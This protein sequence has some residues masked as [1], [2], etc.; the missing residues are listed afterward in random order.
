MLLEQER[1]VEPRMRHARFPTDPDTQP[2]LLNRHTMISPAWQQTVSCWFVSLQCPRGSQGLASQPLAP[3]VVG[4]RSPPAAGSPCWAPARTPE[5]SLPGRALLPSHGSS[6]QSAF[7][8][9]LSRQS[10]ILI[11]VASQ[12]NALRKKKKKK[13]KEKWKVCHAI[14]QRCLAGRREKWPHAGSAFHNLQLLQ[15]R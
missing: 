3:Q 14:T 11:F 5:P 15:Q 10:L 12:G 6:N 2:R 8:E 7:L 1:E 4:G 9:T 13:G